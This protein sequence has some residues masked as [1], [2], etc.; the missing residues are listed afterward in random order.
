[1]AHFTTPQSAVLEW[2]THLGS[3]WRWNCCFTYQR[4]WCWGR[5]SGVHR[6]RSCQHCWENKQHGVGASCAIALALMALS[7]PAF[8]TLQ[9]RAPSLLWPP[10][11]PSGQALSRTAITQPDYAQTPRRG[12]AVRRQPLVPHVEGTCP[13][14][15]FQLPASWAAPANGCCQLL[16]PGDAHLYE[17]VFL[18]W[19]AAGLLHELAVDLALQLGV[20]EADLQGCLGQ[21]HVVVHGGSLHR[22]VDEELAGLAGKGQGPRQTNG[23]LISTRS[24]S[25]QTGQPPMAPRRSGLPQAALSKRERAIHCLR[26]ALSAEK[27]ALG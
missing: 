8:S 23:P 15:S 24:G 21:R 2:L 17:R 22:H 3:A 11:W 16:H 19:A 18:R 4:K 25:G 26:A 20:N 6:A 13:E 10:G 27:A 9:T 5:K 1:M 14:P 12:T 7:D